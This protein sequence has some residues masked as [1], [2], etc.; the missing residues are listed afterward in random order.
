[1]QASLQR[2]PAAGLLDLLRLATP[3]V[4]S[5]LALDGAVSLQLACCTPPA[6]LTAADLSITQ[7]TLT[8]AGI[9][10]VAAQNV[11]GSLVNGALAIQPIALDLGGLKPV[12]LGANLTWT[13]YTLHLTGPAQRQRLQQLAQALPPFGDG[14]ASFYVG[15]TPSDSKSPGPTSTDPVTLDLIATRPWVGLQTSPQQWSP[16]PSIKPTPTRKHTRH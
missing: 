16:A 13:G 6:W 8:Q 10:F 4:S 3:R 15:P 11:S 7:A 1:M 9:P 14:L 5:D 2:F 12:Q